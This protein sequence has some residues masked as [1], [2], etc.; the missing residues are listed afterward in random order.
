MDDYLKMNYLVDDMEG[1]F[2]GQTLQ[3]RSPG[4]PVTQASLHNGS[5]EQ[6]LGGPEVSV[7]VPVFNREPSLPQGRASWKYLSSTATLQEI[8]K[9]SPKTHSQSN[10]STQHR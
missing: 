9:K 3:Q 8:L 7:R 4:G 10:E 6:T 2:E 1:L 5:K